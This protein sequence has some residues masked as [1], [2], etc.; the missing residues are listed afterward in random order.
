[1]HAKLIA[2]IV[3]LGSAAG[4]CASTATGS[5]AQPSGSPSPTS[6]QSSSAKPST[7]STPTTQA[8][9]STPS[10]PPT[11]TVTVTKPPP[12]PAATA[13]SP[14]ATPAPTAQDP[15]AVVSAF[16]AAINAQDY[17]TAWK[18]GGSNLGSSY[19]DF[20]AGFA[21]TAHDSLTITGVQG[22]TVDVHLEALQ[23]DGS[24]KVYDGFY[25]VSNGAITEGRLS[26]SA[27]T[28]APTSPSALPQRGE[29]CPDADAGLTAQDASGNTLT[30]V[31]ESGAFH[32][33]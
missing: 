6:T 14:A 3:V 15:E 31:Y 29:F 4:G 28:V 16:Y 30:C 21:G 7:P 24:T 13:T 33:H 22:N 9:P 8:T 5:A 23:S 17:A 18:L 25:I 10:A 26:Q 2:L 19:S 32:W 12:A 11:T 1:M 27:T 20:A